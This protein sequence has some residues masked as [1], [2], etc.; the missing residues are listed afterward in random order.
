MNDKTG[1]IQ[2]QQQRALLAQ[3][4]VDPDKPLQLP[5]WPDDV[6]ALP[7]DFARSA[8]FTV[9][10]RS[11]PRSA[12]QSVKLFTFNSDVEINY[13][14][15][16]LR[17]EDD[18]L[19]WQQM[20]DYAKHFPLGRDIEFTSYQLCTD[21]GWGIN[22]R[23]YKKVEECLTRLKATAIN[24]RSNRLGELKSF[25]LID[26]FRIE[27]INSKRSRIVISIDPVILNLFIGH[28]YSKV[29]W[30][31][32]RDLSPISRRLFDYVASHREPY[33][34]KLE[35]FRGICSSDC[36]R[37]KKW[38]EMAKQ[39]CDELVSAG[40]VKAA[41]VVEDSIVCQRK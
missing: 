33:P 32:Y 12:L 14:G 5:F 2:E 10:K 40:L 4:G 19:V 37:P 7:N 38:R 36:Q 3:H 15:I 22:G 11:E 41:W 31:T 18:E 13:T 27:A 17:A 25:S 21:L 30:S 8:L 28:Y 29:V 26:K 6:R 23:Y 34:L 20:L 16:E 24:F 35:T 1:L 39:A 9:K